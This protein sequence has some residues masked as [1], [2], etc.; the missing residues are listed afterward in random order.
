MN[1]K[2]AALTA[3]AVTCGVSAGVLLGVANYFYNYGI[4]SPRDK[5]DNAESIA[6]EP[7]CYRN[8][9]HWMNEHV[10]RKDLYLMSH[11]GLQLHANYIKASDPDCH[12]YA[13]CVHGFTDRAEKMGVYARRFYEEYGMS[14]L[15]PDLRGHGDSEGNYAGMGYLDSKDIIRWAESIVTMDPKAVIILHGMSMGAATVLMACGGELPEAVKA[16]IADSGYTSAMEEYYYEYRKLPA[17][18]RI[19]PAELI[20]PLVRGVCLAR[21]HYDIAKASPETAVRSA[22]APILF[23]HGDADDFVPSSMMP[24]LYAAAACKKDFLWIHGAGHVRSVVVNPDKY[25]SK[26]EEFL[27]DVSPFILKENYQD[28][29][30][31]VDSY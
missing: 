19:L 1:K 15:L 4:D 26:V 28:A 18:S 8:G 27:N 13:I 2:R 22:K 30:P 6:K 21:A 3:A 12:R 24:K 16:V 5:G 9:R 10:R 14:V 25:W 23:I 29:D 17:K 7:A 11:D 20:M 31:F